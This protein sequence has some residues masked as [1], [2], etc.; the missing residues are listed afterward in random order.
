MKQIPC[1]DLIHAHCLRSWLLSHGI[2]ADVIHECANGLYLP[3]IL[4][5]QVA[6]DE[7]DVARYETLSAQ[8]DPPIDESFIQP[9]SDEDV[10][11]E[12]PVPGAATLPS[13]L[14]LLVFGAVGGAFLAL[15]TIVVGFLFALF[16]HQRLLSADPLPPDLAAQ[17]NLLWELPLLG[18]IGAIPVYFAIRLAAACK[19]RNG[20]VPWW[21]RGL[22]LF[23]LLCISDIGLILLGVYQ[24]LSWR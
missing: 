3:D 15:T 18:V 6:I 4:P 22:A 21:T 17:G 8:P 13:F 24:I 16:G 20:E 5:A 11:E 10:P 9:E 14:E 1:R 19:V 12:K 7:A 23:F 2:K